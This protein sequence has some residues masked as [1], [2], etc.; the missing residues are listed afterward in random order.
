ME[1]FN[2]SKDCQSLSAR[3]KLKFRLQWK[4]CASRQNTDKTNGQITSSFTR[5]ISIYK[6]LHLR[7]RVN[8]IAMIT[9]TILW[10]FVSH[11]GGWHL[12]WLATW[13][14]GLKFELKRLIESSW[15]PAM[16]ARGQIRVVIA[17]KRNVW[18]LMKT[19]S[20]YFVNI[21]GGWPQPVRAKSVQLENVPSWPKPL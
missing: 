8:P 20:S 13:W 16:Q 18:R 19:G 5:Y 10:V 21:Y 15:P 7:R 11:H 3:G 9:R 14:T 2:S 17:K 1:R 6:R 4:H 12:V